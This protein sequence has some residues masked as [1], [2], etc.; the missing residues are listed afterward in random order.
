MK[1]PVKQGIN[2]LLN[3]FE[4]SDEQLAGFAQ[5]EKNSLQTNPLKAS[6]NHSKM[7]LSMVASFLVMGLFMGQFLGGGASKILTSDEQ[8]YAI[9]SEL[10]Y[11]HLK[12]KPLEVAH[13]NLNQVT[14]YFNRLDFNPLASSLVAA[15]S[16]NLIGGRYCSIKGNIAAQLRMKDDQGR[17][18]TLFESRYQAQDF[19]MLPNI[20]QGQDPK[21]L[22][23]D[24][25]RVALWVEKG[26]VM[27]LVSEAQ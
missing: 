11:N 24:G 25:Q 12:F 7:W 23:V 21:V 9:A 15:L 26:L 18:S 10:S 6:V 5:L 16:S 19:S 14:G 17:I 13:S 8:V 22:Y 20:E 2:D 3:D 1:K 27:A 4:L